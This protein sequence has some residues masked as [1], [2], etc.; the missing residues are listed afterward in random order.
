[1]L[2]SRS[3]EIFGVVDGCTQWALVSS[4]VPA[5]PLSGRVAQGSLLP[6]IH[7]GKIELRTPNP[8]THMVMKLR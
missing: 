2:G 5:L 6:Q 7:F 1:M 4:R 8:P 3:R